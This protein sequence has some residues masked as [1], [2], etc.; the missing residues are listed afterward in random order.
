MLIADLLSQY[1]L[2]GHFLVTFNS[3]KRFLTHK[4]SQS[5]C[6]MALYS[7]SAVDRDT[8]DCFLLRHDT[9]FPPTNTQYH[10]VERL[11]SRQLAQSVSQYP[12][13][14]K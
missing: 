14:F 6:A 1:N 10:D 11:S 8:T 7:A 12:S 3:D 4:I 9:K 5:P 2:E 13:T